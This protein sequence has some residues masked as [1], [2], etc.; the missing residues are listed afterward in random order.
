VPPECPPFD[1]VAISG[2]IARNQFLV[3]AMTYSE[4][5]WTEMGRHTFDSR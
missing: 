5:Q 2:R 1:F 4:L 3:F